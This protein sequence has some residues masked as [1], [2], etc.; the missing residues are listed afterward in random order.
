MVYKG[1]SCIDMHWINLAEIRTLWQADVRME[2][3]F[4]IS[5]FCRDVNV[6]FSLLGDSPPSELYVP[7][8]QNTLF[9]CHRSCEQEE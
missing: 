1:R 4:F 7:I 5:N 8:F 9:H 3:K 6:V 2:M